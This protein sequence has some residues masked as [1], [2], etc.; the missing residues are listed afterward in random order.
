LFYSTASEAVRSARALEHYYLGGSSFYSG[1]DTFRS[2]SPGS[3]MYLSSVP[4]CNNLGI[5]KNKKS[6]QLGLH[7][8]S[9]ALYTIYTPWPK[10]PRQWYT[11]H[12]FS[13]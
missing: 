12:H 1:L 9:F 10:N 13:L 5:E 2:L 11:N 3:Y 8:L 4:L 7:L 6:S